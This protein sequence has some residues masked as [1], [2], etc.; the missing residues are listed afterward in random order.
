MMEQTFRSKCATH[1]VIIS[2]PDPKGKVVIASCQT[3]E[4]ALLKAWVNCS[5]KFQP[6]Q[7][8]I[9][10]NVNHIIMFT[11]RS[12]YILNYNRIMNN[13]THHTCDE[14]LQYHRK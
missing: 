13:V 11:T 3:S 5:Q 6:E 12:Y 2:E 4:N 8:C 10:Y 9:N 7:Y 14:H 1:S